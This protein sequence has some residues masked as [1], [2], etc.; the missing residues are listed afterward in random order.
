MENS[1]KFSNFKRSILNLNY[2]TFTY[3]KITSIGFLKQIDSVLKSFTY[4]SADRKKKLEENSEKKQKHFFMAS[5]VMTKNYVN[6]FF[7]VLLILS[8]FFIV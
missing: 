7:L 4:N 6:I 5:K 1:S 3:N 2:Q 8:K